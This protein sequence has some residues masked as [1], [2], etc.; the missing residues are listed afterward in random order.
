MSAAALKAYRQEDAEVYVSIV[1]VWELVIK[2]S[3]DKLRLGEPIRDVIAKALSCG[4]R[5]LPLELE[6][7]LRLQALPMHHKDPFDRLLAAQALYEGM[8]VVGSD[9]M[10]DRYGVGR[11][12]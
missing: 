2:T 12:W 8:T 7:V 9:E 5:M 1:S 6:H 11:I 3:L 4:I 10:F